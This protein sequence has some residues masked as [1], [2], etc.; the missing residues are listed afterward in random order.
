[1]LPPYGHYCHGWVIT[2]SLSSSIISNCRQNSPFFFCRIQD[3]DLFFQMEGKAVK[4]LCFNPE[5]STPEDIWGERDPLNVLTSSILPS[6]RHHDYQKGMCEDGLRSTGSLFCP[7]KAATVTRSAVLVLRLGELDPVEQP[8]GPEEVS[9]LLPLGPLL[10]LLN[11]S[12]LWDL[13][14][15]QLLCASVY[16]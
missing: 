5:G 14:R 7:D 10:L 12:C 9:L 8:E 1:M 13:A 3:L 4:C 2:R 16:T 11:R 6:P 15:T